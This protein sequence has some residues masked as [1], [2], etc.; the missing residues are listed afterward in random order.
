MQHLL[1]FIAACVT[2]CLPAILMTGCE[3]AGSNATSAETTDDGLLNDL[4]GNLEENDSNEAESAKST[5]AT[6]VAR[7]SRGESLELRL[8]PGD[9]FP[10]IKTIE[11][12]LIQRSEQYPAMAQTKLELSM[13]ID[14]REVRPDAILMSVSYSRVSYS[15]DINGQ[16]IAFDSDRHQGLI[17]DD[18]VPYAGMV[19]N[20]FSFWLG[21]DNKIRELV[22][23][24]EFLQRCVQQV[25]LERR[26]SM[27]SEISARFGD[28][29]VANFVDDTIGLLPYNTDVDSDAATRV[30][31]GDVW[32]RERRLM[33]PVPIYL[34][35]TYRLISLNDET[36]EIDITGRIAS[37][38]TYT[39]V[40]ST[41][42]SGVK[43]LGGQS[44]GSCIVDRQTGLPLELKRT[45]FLNMEVTTEDGQQVA[46]DKQI[47]T[48][49]R[50]FPQ[51]RG[52]V[53]QAQP[54]PESPETHPAATARLNSGIQRAAGTGSVAGGNAASNIPTTADGPVRAAYPQ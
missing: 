38:E 8:R 2:A 10:L 25:S 48:T 16:R 1:R 20:G 21:R 54:L 44:I 37:G 4:L 14:V 31:T 51:A 18:V 35:S 33:Q 7:A 17:P 39:D 24:N 26:Q 6:P 41:Q 29:G 52:P 45:R 53:V 47:I 27:L 30:V 32:T 46:Q 12:T 9:R 43:I 11:Q 19:N 28:D 15:H 23:Y 40:N 49:I 13:A 5:P 42:K 3:H 22:D 34:T 36:A 50:A